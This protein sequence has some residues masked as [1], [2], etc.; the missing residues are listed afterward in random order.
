[1]GTDRYENLSIN[2]S[3]MKGNSQLCNMLFWGLMEKDESRTSIH[4]INE[5][6]TRLKLLSQALKL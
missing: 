5:R 1:M 6:G 2:M 3:M 4:L